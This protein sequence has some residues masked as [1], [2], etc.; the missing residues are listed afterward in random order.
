MT[1]IVLLLVVYGCASREVLDP[2]DGTVPADVDLSGTWR[3]RSD[4]AAEQKRLQDAIRKTGGGAGTDFD[5]IVPGKS[6]KKKRSKKGG[7]VHVFLE[8]GSLLKITQTP[9]ALY[10]S[11][12]RSVVEE[13]RFGENRLISIGEIQAQRVTGW[14]GNSLVVDTLDKNSTKLRE[15]YEVIDDGRSMQRTITFRNKDL[16]EES[17]VQEFARAN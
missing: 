10:V 3:I 1:L 17:I 11:F 2:I 8:T 6:N 5:E 13:F 9:H 7:L 16:T 14:D 12:D 15:R 4:M